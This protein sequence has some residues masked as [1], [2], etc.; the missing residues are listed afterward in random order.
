MNP[1]IE[2]WAREAG[3]P[4]LAKTVYQSALLLIVVAGDEYRAHRQPGQQQHE[5]GGIRV[6]GHLFDGDGQAEDAGTGATQ[7]GGQ[8]QA[9]Q[10]GV[11]ERLEQIGRVL[12]GAVDLP[13]PGLDLVLGQATDALLQLGQFGREVEVHEGRGYPSIRAALGTPS[14]SPRTGRSPGGRVSR[15]RPTSSAAAL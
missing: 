6:L 12:A 15:A 11:T 14:P 3:S 7:F 13:G 5:G 8:A 9:E 4:V 2:S 1:V 10:I